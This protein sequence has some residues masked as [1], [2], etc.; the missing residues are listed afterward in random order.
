MPFPHLVAPDLIRGP[1]SSCATPDKESGTP[2]QVRGDEGRGEWDRRPCDVS[3]SEIPLDKLNH[4]GYVVRRRRGGCQRRRRSTR[5]VRVGGQA[6]ASLASP[7]INGRRCP[8][9]APASAPPD[10]RMNQGYAPRQAAGVRARPATSLAP[11][12]R[13]C[14]GFVRV[15]PAIRKQSRQARPV[16]SR[17]Q[18]PA[19]VPSASCS[20]PGVIPQ[21][22][23]GD[24][25]CLILPG[26]GRGTIRQDGGGGYPPGA[27]LHGQPRPRTPS[28]TACGGGPPPRE[29]GGA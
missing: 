17:H 6:F 19:V 12:G 9:D 20:S 1:A 10:A 24:Q 15:P 28:T 25:A 14:V 21:S 11:Q 29:R 3:R 13:D 2:D 18:T 16:W 26:T 8:A 22:P 5:R 7:Q 23:A 4:M 27:S